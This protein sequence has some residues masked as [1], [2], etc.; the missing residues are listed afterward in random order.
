MDAMMERIVLRGRMRGRNVR[1]RL[2][3]PGI[4]ITLPA[5]HASSAVC[6]IFSGVA[7]GALAT[8]F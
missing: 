2:G 6:A 3:A 4:A 1:M 7:V 8:V 5:A